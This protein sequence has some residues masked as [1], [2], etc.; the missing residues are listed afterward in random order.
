[1]TSVDLKCKVRFPSKR[2][3]KYISSVQGLDFWN[4]NTCITSNFYSLIMRGSNWCPLEQTKLKQSQIGV[5]VLAPRKL[6]CCTI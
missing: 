1:M 6:S 3:D 2:Q 4:L 5:Y